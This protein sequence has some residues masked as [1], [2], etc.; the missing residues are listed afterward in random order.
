MKI[1]DFGKGQ[2]GTKAHLFVLN[3]QNGMKISLTE[4]GAH[5]VSVEIPCKDGTT[6]DVV[7]GYDDVTGYESDQSC[8]GATIGRNANRIKDAMFCLNG[9]SFQLEANDNGNNSH[10]GPDGYQYRFWDVT[11]HGV[12]SVTFSLLSPDG[13]QGFPGELD[14]HVTYSLTDRNQ[15][16][17]HFKGTTSQDTIVNMTNHSYFNLNGHDAGNILNHT[18]SIDADIYTPV[19][20]ETWIPTGEHAT[21]TGTPMDFRQSK[22]IGA[23]I[24]ADFDQLNIVHDYNHNYILNKRS[25]D[26]EDDIGK[27]MFKEVEELG[28]SCGDLSHIRMTAYTNLPAV[29]LYTAGYME[30]IKGKS[31]CVYHKQQGFCLEAQFTPNAINMPDEEQPILKAGEVYDRTI[32][33]EFDF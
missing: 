4:Y 24:E 23:E 18:L 12:D 1:L 14:M 15:I 9:R 22:Q 28:E 17:I 29:Q 8:L 26:A 10:S 13:D 6:R 7:L 5:L 32:I 21:V 11:D 3:N 19:K 16:V 25:Y 31:G 30:N 2:N 27:Q 20:D 33:Y